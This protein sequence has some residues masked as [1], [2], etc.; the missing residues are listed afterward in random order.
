MALSR[1]TL[2]LL[3]SQALQEAIKGVPIVPAAR[4]M[5]LLRVEL[6]N[7]AWELQSAHVD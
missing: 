7:G 4:S 5:N 1:F 6:Q 3:P 2:L